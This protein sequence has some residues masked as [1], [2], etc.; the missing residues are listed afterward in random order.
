MMDVHPVFHVSLLEPVRDDSF[1]GQ[2]A[3]PPGPII[4]EGEPEYQVEDVLDSRMFRRQ[5]QYLIKWHGWDILTWEYA[6]G[7]NKLRA[8]EEFHT[9]YPNKPGPLPE[10]TG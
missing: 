2:V 1:P 10:D 8:I 6:I 9:Q 3:T 5:L 7:V 4:I